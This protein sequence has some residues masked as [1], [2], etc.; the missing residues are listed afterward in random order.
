MHDVLVNTDMYAADAD[1]EIY[2]MYPGTKKPD[3]TALPAWLNHTAKAADLAKAFVWL[4]G[5]TTKDTDV[6]YW[7]SQQDGGRAEKLKPQMGAG[8]KDVNFP[9]DS[10]YVDYNDDPDFTGERYIDLEYDLPTPDELFLNGSPIATLP[11][12]PQSLHIPLDP[13]DDAVSL[14]DV[15]SL[16]SGRQYLR[17]FYHR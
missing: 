17:L 8:A 5:N 16:S 15:L 2:A 9:L 14:S 7:N 12:G 10:A 3:G 13:L 11:A 1:K 6:F 4:K